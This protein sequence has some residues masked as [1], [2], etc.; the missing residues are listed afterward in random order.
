LFFSNILTLRIEK[1]K[2]DLS[3]LTGVM[4]APSPAWHEPWRWYPQ[5]ATQKQ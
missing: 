2:R 5:L 4:V 1:K 3:R